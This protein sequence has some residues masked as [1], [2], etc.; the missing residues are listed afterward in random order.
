MALK[1]TIFADVSDFGLSSSANDTGDAQWGIGSSIITVQPDISQTH[2][3]GSENSGG[4]SGTTTQHRYYGY[5]DTTSLPSD[6]SGEVFFT[7]TGGSGALSS[8]AGTM[9]LRLIQWSS[10]ST[11]EWQSSFSTHPLLGTNT[12]SWSHSAGV[13]QIS[14]STFSVGTPF[15][16][17]LGRSSVTLNTDA[18]TQI[19][20]A[21]SAGTVNDPRLEVT[22][23]S[24]EV[25]YTTPGTY[26]WTVPAGVTSAQFEC[27][28]GG[29]P[30]GAISAQAPSGGGADYARSLIAVTPGQQFTITVPGTS[31]QAS[32]ANTAFGSPAT[33][34]RSGTT[35]ARAATGRNAAGTAPA[36]ASIGDVIFTG[37]LNAAAQGG[38][39]ARGGSG[40]GGGA[41]SAGN[42]QNG[43]NT[44]GANADGKAGGAGGTPD[45]GAG[46]AGGNSGTAGSPGIA[47]G[48]GGGG[49]G[50]SNT[51]GGAGAAGQV[52]ISY[53]VEASGPPTITS[54]NTGSV[55]ENSPFT[56]NLT[57]DKSV[58]WS[59]VGGADASH[60]S[61]SGNVLSMAAKDYENPQDA[62]QNN[63]YIVTIRATDT[64]SQITDQTITVTVL[65][66]EGDVYPPYLYDFTPYVGGS[67]GDHPHW[68]I[69]GGEEITVGAGGS[70]STISYTGI[71]NVVKDNSTDFFGE[72][73]F[74]RASGGSSR[75]EFY[76]T[77]DS[78][79]KF[80]AVSLDNNGLLIYR[81]APTMVTLKS[82]TEGS[83]LSGSIGFH[84]FT[85]QT[86]TELRVY[87]NGFLYWSHSD[88]SGSRLTSLETHEV[89]F[90][91]N[92][93]TSTPTTIHSI[94]TNYYEPVRPPYLY[95]FTGL[96]V[97]GEHPHWEGNISVN[98][99]GHLS[100]VNAHTWAGYEALYGSTDVFIDTEYALANDAVAGMWIEFYDEQW[101]DAYWLYMST[102]GIRI[103]KYV[104]GI[105]T[106]IKSASNDALL[107]GSLGF[108]VFI[109]DTSTELRLYRN[110]LLHWSYSDTA[111]DRITSFGVS[112]NLRGDGVSAPSIIHAIRTNY[113]EVPFHPSYLYDFSGYAAGAA[114]ST[115]P[116][117]T[118]LRTNSPQ[119]DN[120]LVFT[121]DGKLEATATGTDFNGWVYQ[122]YS[123]E[124]APSSENFI[125]ITFSAAATHP[126]VYLYALSSGASSARNGYD[127]SAYINGNAITY[128]LNRE[129]NSS[130]TVLLAWDNI[131]LGSSLGL[132]AFDNGSET[133]LECYVDGFLHRT[134]TDTSA[135]RRTSGVPRLGVYEDLEDDDLVIH[136]LRTNY[137]P[138]EPP[139]QTGR[140]LPPR[141][142]HWS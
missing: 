9:E 30:G 94:R 132:R 100:S 133:I 43:L 81:Q 31:T 7:K 5:F 42:G 24:T 95:D 61:I 71:Q 75:V 20:S 113:E 126:A 62:D 130:P 37:G 1:Y 21:D 129:T 110:G 65:D 84:I 19:A 67:A 102:T 3:V 59:I 28:G 10:A 128:R 108:H 66:V 25:P 34:V 64:T 32:G 99:Q 51:V 33:V 11:S 68:A 86:S 98:A 122:I 101:N 29:S 82:A 22:V 17:A 134:Y 104:G 107:A 54:S 136:S 87:L 116:N 44:G 118:P 14:F 92:S 111:T 139:P 6:F 78:W 74:S 97:I 63:T 26:T 70:L 90:Q 89:W 135:D 53:V 115:H 15:R 85:T 91:G 79:D 117:W 47:P 60:F 49:A 125:E 50:S 142:S 52:L 77:Q 112:M 76:T 123:E 38:G 16:F 72:V 80:Y 39:G 40:G 127:I 109:T 57:A 114:F 18:T 105:T 36:L 124:I 119:R 13:E 8:S 35:H 23:A 46:G 141:H 106:T 12:S 83:I 138:S 69:S 96:S 45:G 131:P 41:G 137:E 58:T 56:K 121:N 2:T 140:R 27:W 4:S 73:S 120:A 55:N 48:G 103:Q 93:T 88:T